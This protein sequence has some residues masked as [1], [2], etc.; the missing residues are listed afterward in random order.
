MTKV[1]Q[2]PLVTLLTDFGLVDPYVSEMKAVI[3]STCPTARIVDITHLVEKFNIRMGAFLLASAVPYFPAGTVHVAVVDPGVGSSRRAIVI[4]TQR[5]VIVG[6]D[7]GLLVPAAQTERILHVYQITNPL[8]MRTTVSATFHG[9]D[10]FAPVAAH[11]ACGTQAKECGDEITDWVESPYFKTRVNQ[12]GAFGEILHIDDFGNIITNLRNDDLSTWNPA[13][14]QMLEISIGRKHI[15]VR[16]VKTYSE[17]TKDEYGLLRGSH[18]FLE[19][20]SRSKSAAHR[21]SAKIGMSVQ[22][23]NA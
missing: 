7:N 9:R 23:S 4:E 11:L 6:P 21:T 19:I 18:G 3:L 22:I 15:P 17:L 1:T 5:C 2:V 8:L 10:I 13:H 20:S 16:H 14:R 12:K